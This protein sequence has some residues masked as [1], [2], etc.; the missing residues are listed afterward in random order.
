MRKL[1]AIAF[2]MLVVA[3][4]PTPA[5]DA[6]I[7]LNTDGTPTTVKGHVNPLSGQ[8]YRLTV[9]ANQRIAIHL[10]STSAKKLVKFSLSRNKYTGKP[11]AGA[12]DVTDWEGTLKEAG[13]YWIGVY[14]LPAAG[15]E[16]FT[17]VVSAP[18]ENKPQ[19]SGTSGHGPVDTSASIAQTASTPESFV[20]RGWN[21]GPSER[22]LEW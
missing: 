20:P 15:E 22:R 4:V 19:E 13:D 2:V 12:K 5:Q 9:D 18:S 6:S 17:L 14:A 16:N 11:L 8:G 21:C 1:V 3:L 10:T 7:K